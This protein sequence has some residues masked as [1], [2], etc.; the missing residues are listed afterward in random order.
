[1]SKK[2]EFVA[3][4]PEKLIE[5]RFSLNA[6]QNDII[7]MVLTQIED[8]GIYQYELDVDKYKKL[9]NTDTSNIYRDLKKAVESFEKKG[10]SLIS[11]ETGERIYFPWFSK[12]HYK[13]N[14]GKILINLDIDFKKILL[15]MK[16]RIYYNIIYTLNFSCQYSKRIYY[17]LKSFEDSGWRIDNLDIL[18]EK[19][20][21]PKS[22]SKYSLFKEFVLKPAYEE[23]NGSS[24]IRFEYK[25]IKTGRK[26]TRLEFYIKSSK[27]EKTE[28]AKKFHDENLEESEEN[29]YIKKV[30][31][32]MNLHEIEAIEAKKIFDS[33]EGNFENIERCYKYCC[34]KKV[35]SIVAYMIKL[36]EPNKFI[37]P[38]ANIPKSTFNNFKQ[39]EYDFKDLENKLL[40]WNR[41]PG[42]GVEENIDNKAWLE[43]IK[44]KSTENLNE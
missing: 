33:A 27:K 10:F 40:G 44:K 23:I 26:V 37:E 39:R 1:M 6:R 4:R 22:Y 11:N 35:D 14:Y 30:M 28:V 25:E 20:E 13:P 42:K 3:M 7:D 24:D 2:G 32:I 17:Y 29:S 18:R 19:L 12:I 5:A 34:Q 8:D 16:K 9:Y 41:E 43:K 15:E 31:A 38:K 21:C 36:V